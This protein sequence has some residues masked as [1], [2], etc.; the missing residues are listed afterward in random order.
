MHDKCTKICH[1]QEILTS[2][3]KFGKCL[4]ECLNICGLCSLNESQISLCSNPHLY[5]ISRAIKK[6]FVITASIENS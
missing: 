6:N 2:G 5:Q 1:L 3:L 4:Y